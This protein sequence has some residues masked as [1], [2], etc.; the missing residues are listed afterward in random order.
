MKVH[1]LPVRQEGP[2]TQLQVEEFQLLEVL[3]S[4]RT[5]VTY[6]AMDSERGVQVAVREFLPAGLAV[7]QRG[8]TVRSQSSTSNKSL[9]ESLAEFLDEAKALADVHHDS[10]IGI[11]RILE[12]NGTAYVVMDYAEGIGLNAMLEQSGK[13]DPKLLQ[14]ILGKVMDA[15]EALHKAELLHLQFRPDAVVLRSDGSPVVLAHRAVHQGFAVARQAFGE[16]PRSRRFLPSPTLYA[17]VELYSTKAKWGAWTDIYSLGAV[18][19]QCVTGEAPPAAADRVIEESL[20]PLDARQHKA[21]PPATLKG[22]QAALETRPE[23]RP[24]T[25]GEWR[26]I[27]GGASPGVRKSGTEG[28]FAKTAARGARLRT[29][30]SAKDSATARRRPRWAVPALTL[31]AVT[32]LVGYVDT[33]V[34]RTPIE[35]PP[36]LAAIAELQSP[37][38]RSGEASVAEP[39]ESPPVQESPVAD[40]SP[41]GV[42]AGDAA[43]IVETEPGGVEV[44]VDGR[45]V[46]RTPLSLAG[47]PAGEFEIVLR[48]PHYERVV[49]PDQGFES[50]EQ[51]RIEQRLVRGTGSLLVTTEPPGAW[52][53]WRDERLIEMTPKLLTGLPAGPIEL[54]IGAPGRKSIIAFTEV[55]KDK[56]GYFAQSLVR[57]TEP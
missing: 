41:V 18:F 7:R 19:Y 55:P 48:H 31:T 2:A 50:G 16:R 22:I 37:I 44:L 47:Q 3:G 28:R 26:K 43:L 45:F 35:E 30:S 49:L 8:G 40:T 15:V 56:T 57:E 4:N 27:L 11:H 42:P 14:S 10:L 51:L 53:E 12:A 20:A 17:P 23:D 46:G 24:K 25:I 21:Y 52:V 54:R 5:G 36:D 39:P 38:A 33:G 32:A 29:A 13:L 34:L 9:E 1:P 6:R